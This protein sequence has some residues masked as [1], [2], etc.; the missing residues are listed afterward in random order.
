MKTLLKHLITAVVL[1]LSVSPTYSIETSE[2]KAQTT[3]INT[4][5]MVYKR[6]NGTELHLD[7]HRAKDKLSNTLPLLIWVHGGAWMRG[8]KDE[9]LTRNGNLARSLIAEGYAIAAVNYRLSHQARF[10]AQLRDINSALNFL[11]EQAEQLN[12][13]T[14]KLTLM[15]RSAGGHLASLVATSHNNFGTSNL[16]DKSDFPKY[17]IISVVSFFGVSDLEQ[18]KGNSGRVDHD[19]PDSAEAK[20]LGASPRSRPDLAKWAS[21]THYVSLKSPP[22]IL[23][24]GDSDGVVPDTQSTLLKSVL[25]DSDVFN[26]LHIAK[27]ARHGDPVFDTD[28]YVSKVVAFVQLHHA[29]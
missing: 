13:D 16:Y 26:A 28:E 20:L 7:L 19:A 23:L 22:F 14:S 2:G 21:P 27:G 4:L 24:H 5:E 6:V 10:P 18:L 12:I 15:G 11:V 3:N 1:G 17:N 8:S 29:K 25:D 9:F